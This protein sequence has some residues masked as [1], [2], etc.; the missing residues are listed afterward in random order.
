[1][2]LCFVRFAEPAEIIA[3]GK[4]V[5]VFQATGD[6][7]ELRQKKFKLSVTATFQNV[8]DFL[9]KQLKMTD[10]PQP[11]VFFCTIFFSRIQCLFI[12]RTFQPTPD[13]P[14]EDLVRVCCS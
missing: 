12:N 3:E 7:P 9:R 5:I 6:A 13:Q 2:V 14:V 4:V 11:L 8:I 10:S 1:M